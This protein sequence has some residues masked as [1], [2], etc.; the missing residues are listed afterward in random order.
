MTLRDLIQNQPSCRVL[1][2]PALHE[3]IM[4]EIKLQFRERINPTLWQSHIAADAGDLDDD[5]MFLSETNQIVEEIIDKFIHDGRLAPLPDAEKSELAYELWDASQMYWW[6]LSNE[7]KPI[8]SFIER[9]FDKSKQ[10]VD[11]S[12]PNAAESFGDIAEQLIIDFA[13][14]SQLYE[15]TKISNRKLVDLRR[16]IN[17]VG[18]IIESIFAAK[19]LVKPYTIGQI[20]NILKK[21]PSSRHFFS[22]DPLPLTQETFLRNLE[23]LKDVRNEYSHGLTNQSSIEDDFSRCVEALVAEP[24]GLLSILYNDVLN[25]DPGGRAGA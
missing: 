17:I 12:F 24:E 21:L 25:Q 7:I 9:L 22:I 20:H 19:I 10:A 18:Q 13:F 3:A 4:A 14:Q 23:I 2:H 1:L 8:L 16:M 6:E 15:Y 5:S 11:S